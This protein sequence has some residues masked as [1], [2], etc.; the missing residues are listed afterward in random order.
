MSA[1]LYDFLQFHDTVARVTLSASDGE[2]VVDGFSVL[3]DSAQVPVSATF[4]RLEGFYTGSSPATV[5]L[6]TGPTFNSLSGSTIVVEK[7]LAPAE[8]AFSE[9]AE[10][11]HDFGI[12]YFTVT[13]EVT[14]VGAG[15]IVAPVFSFSGLFPSRIFAPSSPFFSG[16]SSEPRGIR[17]ANAPKGKADR[18]VHGGARVYK[19]NS[20]QNLMQR[21]S[22]TDVGGA[23]RFPY[24]DYRKNQVPRA[25]R[26]YDR[27]SVNE[28]G[29]PVFF[30]SSGSQ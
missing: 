13:L 28:F 22:D 8:G 15:T 26:H 16:A 20:V 11:S 5:R 24:R 2:S 30:F 6:R 19:I 21:P 17:F 23:I 29:E 1:P 7:N 18:V 14:D 27:R 25:V 10:A 9:A 12:V 3:V 4:F